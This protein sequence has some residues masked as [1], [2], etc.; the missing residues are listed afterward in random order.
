MDSY[1]GNIR[2]EELR[3]RVGEEWFADFDAAS[4][5]GN[6]DFAVAEPIDK[7]NL[8]PDYRIYYLWA[9]SKQG[10]SHDIIESFIQLILTIG[11]EKT[12][13]GHL[14]PMFLGAFD[15]EK[16]AFL[17]YNK[18]MDTFVQ[19]DFNWNVTPS[20]H[21]TKEF[22]QLYTKLS[23]GLRDEIVTFRYDCDNR[24]LRQFIKQN[25]KNLSGDVRKARVTINNFV[26]VYNRWRQE[27]M[28]TILVDWKVVKK[29]GILDSNFF[30]ADLM[31]MNNATILTKLRVLLLGDVYKFKIGQGIVGLMYSD[32]LFRDGQRAHKA[33][34]N[35]Y[36][37]P[38]KKEYWQKII[39]RKDLLV[40]QDIREIRGTFYTPQKWVQLSQEYLARELGEDWQ[41]RYYIWDLCG[42]TGNMEVGLTNKLNVYVSTLDPADVDVIHQHIASGANLLDRHVFQFDFL[43]DSFHL[44]HPEESKLPPSLIDI[45][46]DSEKRQRLVIYINPP[47]AE[48]SNARTSTGHGRNRPGLSATDVKARLSKQL[49]RAGN[50]IFAQFFARIITEIPSSILAAFSTLKTLQG[51]NFTGFRDRYRA[52]LG[53]IFLVPA[54]TFD[55]V[56]GHFP[57]GFQIYH[58]GI[59]E[60]FSHINADVF[61]ANG[62]FVGTKNIH[63]YDNG[64]LIIDWYRHFYDKKGKHLAY[65]R[66][67]GTDFQNNRGVFITLSPSANDLKQVKGSW[68]TP[69]NLREACIYFAVRLCIP[70]TWLNDRDQFC[71]PNDG[72]M[73]DPLFQSDCLT[74]ALFS[75]KNN[76]SIADGTNHWIPFTETEV[77]AHERF[78]SHFMTN[79]IHGT[80]PQPKLKTEEM[81]KDSDYKEGSLAFINETSSLA[82]KAVHLPG[83]AAPLE[84]SPEAQAVFAAGRELWRYYHGQ[85]EANPNAALYDIRLHFQGINERGTMNATSNDMHYNNLMDVLR[86]HLKDLAKRIEPKVYAYGFL[87]D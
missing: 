36:E 2:E 31:S 42:G 11:K 13:D 12:M 6:V 75:M 57:I 17:P 87:L 71:Q 15:A 41:E 54:N 56:T 25:F 51:P 74:F 38:P 46:K 18:M 78:D 85:P 5:L 10:T 39:D 68:V 26:H 79:Y 69:N 64:K 65:L 60:V 23:D 8:F 84:F 44:D 29:Y 83:H 77:D 59:K 21:K 27:V 49:G 86:S 82:A 28:P 19:N 66:Y 16:I 76:I 30:L 53:R 35:R 80:L 40:P 47:Y 58:T 9:E 14:P 81:A 72:W 20:N 7:N 52:K 3:I 70:A 55:N 45:L 22:R 73:A 33:F 32:I 48:A 61:D 63:A 34:W 50:E 4:K 67:L 43:N 1:Y 24:D 37:R 62:A